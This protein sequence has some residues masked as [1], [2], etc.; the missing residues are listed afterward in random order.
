MCF[1]FENS[2][3]GKGSEGLLAHEIAH[4]WFGMQLPK[5]TGIICGSVKI[6]S[7]SDCRLSEMTY[8][9]EMLQEV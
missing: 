2:V 4:Q 7:L 3:T 6:C 8:G 9:E 1:L 5:M